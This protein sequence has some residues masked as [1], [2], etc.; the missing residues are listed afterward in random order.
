MK[1]KNV[2]NII[3]IQA[4]KQFT[5]LRLKSQSKSTDGLLFVPGRGLEKN[6]KSRG[7]ASF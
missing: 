2:T 3:R 1:A 4:E 5:E 7:G 6:E